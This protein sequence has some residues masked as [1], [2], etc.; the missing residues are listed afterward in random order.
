VGA[1]VGTAV[2]FA[3]VG[4]GVVGEGVGEVVEGE[5]VGEGLVGEGLVGAWMVE[6]VEGRLV[7][8]GLGGGSLEV[9]EGE[10]LV[11]EGLDVREETKRIGS[12]T[13]NS[14]P[15]RARIKDHNSRANFIKRPDAMMSC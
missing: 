13:T 1:R 5:L 2:V 10:L 7:G 3:W 8:V 12:T 15:S 4:D 11:G 6:V 9:V 14:K